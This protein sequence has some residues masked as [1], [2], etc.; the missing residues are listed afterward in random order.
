MDNFDALILPGGFGAA[1]N[2]STFAFDGAKMTIQ[3]Q[4]ASALTAFHAAK[5][6]IGLICI[7]PVLGGKLFPQAE[8]TIGK[9]SGPNWSLAG[10]AD[11][12]KSFG[13]VPV[14]KEANEVHVD[15]AQKIVSC[16]SYMHD[17]ATPASIFE[18]IGLL[19]KETLAIN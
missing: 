3:P 4:V 15:L 13:A 9:H 14:E 10:A 2:L 8:L 12:I 1:K 6:P 18:N 5:K 7:A 11:A 16:P 17:A 19:V